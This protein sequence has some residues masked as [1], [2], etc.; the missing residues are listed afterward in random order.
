VCGVSTDISERKRSEQALAAERALLRTLIDALPDLVFTKDPE[1]RFRLCNAAELKHLGLTHEDELLGKTVFDLYSRELAELYHADDMEALHGEAVLNREEPCVDRD[2]TPRW[3]LTIKVPLRDHDNKI[4]G[5]VGISRDITERKRAQ[6][7][8]Q[9]AQKL[10]ALGTLA[11]G[12]AHDFNNLL[13]AIA[14]N[15]Q[16]AIA[17]LPVEHPV[18][19]SLEGD[20]EGSRPRDRSGTPDSRVH[21]RT[22]AGAHAHQSSAR[23]G[24][25]A[26]AVTRHA[27]AMI[28]IE[29]S[30]AP[31]LPPVTAD[32][33]EIHQVVVNLLTNAATPS[34]SAAG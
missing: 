4:R 27:S 34:G 21:T 23:R 31:H 11:G 5:L 30:F 26:D 24:R 16:L 1:G 14:G 10:E 28:R 32:S 13:L 9:R 25:G 22:A 7:Y 33:T 2:G 15:V 29:A 3:H 17:D 12:V 6:E 19:Q 18:Q 8:H 20:T